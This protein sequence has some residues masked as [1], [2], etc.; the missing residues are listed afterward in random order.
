MEI[1]VEGRSGGEMTRAQQPCKTLVFLY[2]S[3]LNAN[4]KINDA[5][6]ILF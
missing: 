1:K 4:D 6:D 2:K 5:N 3:I